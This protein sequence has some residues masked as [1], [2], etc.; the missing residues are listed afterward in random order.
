MKLSFLLPIILLTSLSCR[1]VENSAEKLRKEAVLI[2]E[3]YAKNQLKTAT[4]TTNVNGYITIEDS[5]KKY[6]FNPAGI[7]TGFIDEDST[8]DAIVTLTS[9]IGED[10]ALVEQLVLLN[11]NG[12]L[13]LIKSVEAD[14]KILRITDRI[15][16]VEVHTRPLYNCTA[17]RAIINYR[18]KN[19]D[20]VKIEEASTSSHD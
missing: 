9:Y 3:N 8:D 18:F 19:G 13:M 12:S 20:L 2:T 11:T 4:I 14:M 17:C 16:T 10:I 7:I 1:Q 15:I 6:V 5:Q